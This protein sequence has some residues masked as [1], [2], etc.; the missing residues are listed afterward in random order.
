[1]KILHIVATVIAI[2]G[3]HPATGAKAA[4]KVVV[5]YLPT[6]HGLPLYVAIE[7]KLFEKAGLE[8]EATKFENPNQI[9][10]SLVSGRADSAPAG[11]AAGITTLAEQKFPGALRVFGLQ[12]SSNARDARNDTL[13]VKTGSSIKSF[14]DLKGKKLAHAPGIQWRTIARTIVKANGLEPDK[15]VDL[16]EI[17]IGLHAQAVIAGTVD[18]ALTLEPVG[19]IIAANNQLQ[20]VVVNPAGTFISDPFFAGAGV[21]TTKFLTE[22]P[23]VAKRFMMV[24]NQAAASIEKDFNAYR[25]YL[26]SYTPVTDATIS[27]V[28]PMFYLGSEDI[29]S[30]AIA[31]YQKFA[32]IFVTNGALK[33]SVDVSKLIVKISDI[34]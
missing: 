9:I 29:D 18:A 34:K 3:L 26:I 16:V 25:K 2:A 6:L 17:A 31:S 10:D 24:I 15:D 21:V 12:G 11:G 13:I 27:Y 28:K 14:V 33:S 1:M 32:D 7:E 22:R 4:D 5:S 23:A 20:T 19:S 30:A 8:V